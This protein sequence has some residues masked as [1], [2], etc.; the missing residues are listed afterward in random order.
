MPVQRVFA[1]LNCSR[2][3]NSGPW[4]A[5]LLGRE[6]DAEPMEGLLEWH[7]QDAGGLQLFE[8]T[9]DAGH[10][11]LTLIVSGLSEE[12]TRLDAEGL[13]PST[14]EEATTVN[15]FMLR[16]PDQNLIVLAEPRATT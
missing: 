10:G 7:H 12:H 3:T 15:L 1:Q 2:V 9:S 14:I 5:K 13:S 11:T 16:D 4:F 8:N 6:A